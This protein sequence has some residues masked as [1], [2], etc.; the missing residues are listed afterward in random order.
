[1]LQSFFQWF[2]VHCR[3][4]EPWLILGKGPSFALAR[5]LDL[6]QYQTLS[7][8]HVAREGPVSVA[9]VI[10]LDVIADCGDAIEHNA[11]VLVM[12]WFPHVGNRVGSRSL[13]QLSAEIPTLERL[14]T[15]NR[16]LWYDLSTSPNR[17]GPGPVV[18]ATYFSAEA[19][20]GLLGAAGA[21]RVRSLGVDGGSAYSGAFDD[22]RDTTLLANGRS[23]FDLQFAGFAR[24][25]MRTGMDFFPL[26]LAVPARVFVA[27]T[28]AELLPLEVLRHSIRRR[29][30]LSMN[31]VPLQVG[32]SERLPEDQALVLTPRSQVLTDLRLI[33]ALPVGEREIVVP[34]DTSPALLLVGSGLGDHLHALASK[35]WGRV[36]IEAQAAVRVRVGLPAFQ[37]ST[38]SALGQ[39]YAADGSE[40]WLS[41]SHPL[42]YLWVR[43][44][45]DAVQ[46]GFLEMEL[47]AEEVKRRHVRPSLLYQVERGLEEPLL[48][49]RRVRQLD[50]DFE[51]AQ[52]IHGENG[53]SAHRRALMAAV[54]R[55]F[56]RRMR[57]YRRRLVHPKAAV[58]VGR[59][60][61]S[62][63]GSG[64]PESEVMAP[65]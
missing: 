17:H 11:G 48:L 41:R 36:P 29:A 4:D 21:R 8:N 56:K 61:I 62:T 27:H 2:E 7:L 34:N 60:V 38:R 5:Q 1:L 23:S 35:V 37:G 40:P 51:P 53:G 9:H 18:E 30:S 10:D 58:S 47:V 28:P 25:L 6:R 42:G 65:Q 19:A 54:A 45:L 50:R 13:A 52:R 31:V 14:K 33:W 39:V 16:L 57:V 22:L 63:P 12:P 64:S 26:D 43:E 44:L 20:L 24:T 3:P 46:H 49:G 15:S 55:E 59:S 32:G